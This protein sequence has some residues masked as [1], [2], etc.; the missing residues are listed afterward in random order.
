LNYKIGYG[1]PNMTATVAVTVMV[2][3]TVAGSISQP[4][5]VTEP[6]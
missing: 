3:V 1:K 2:A 5:V 4:D 6:A